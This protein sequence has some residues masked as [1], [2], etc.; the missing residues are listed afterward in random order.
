M[1]W[2][3]GASGWRANGRAGV[4]LKNG[5][6]VCARGGDHLCDH[7]LA[8]ARERA[9]AELAVARF[10]EDAVEHQSV[11]VHIEAQPAAPPS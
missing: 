3:I 4:K 9:E 5:S 2:R 6:K 10:V 7:G 1:G 8:R 11:K